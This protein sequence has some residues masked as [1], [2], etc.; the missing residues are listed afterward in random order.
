MS[1]DAIIACPLSRRVKRSF[2][3][4]DAIDIKFSDGRV[5]RTQI[6]NLSLPTPNPEHGWIIMLQPSLRKE[7]FRLV[8]R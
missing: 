7:T 5:T 4:G 1:L 8:L 3:I 2:T 6:A